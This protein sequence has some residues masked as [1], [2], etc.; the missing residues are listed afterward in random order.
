[1]ARTSGP[2]TF[3][4]NRL[5][6]TIQLDPDQVASIDRLSAFKRT[7]RAALVREAIDCFLSVNNS[8]I[9]INRTV[10]SSEA[11]DARAA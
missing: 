4:G 5:Q 3:R 10:D 9:A 2:T 7:S 1:M 11:D 6:V 8:Q